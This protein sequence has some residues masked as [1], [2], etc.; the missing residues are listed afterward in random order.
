MAASRA[1]RRQRVR[2]GREPAV[3]GARAP[4]PTAWSSSTSG[5]RSS[6]ATTRP[7]RSSP[8]G[9]ATPWSR[10]PSPPWPPT[11]CGAGAPSASSSCSARP[12]GSSACGPCRWPTSTG[13]SG[14]LVVVEDISERRRLENVRRDFVANISHELKTP[15]RRARPCWPRRCS[16]RTTPTV[17][18]RLAERLATEAFRV[19]Q[20]D[21]RPA[22]A[23][24]GSRSP[25]GWPP[26]TSAWRTFVADAADRVRPA[27]EQRG[28]EIDVERRAG[29][30]VGG[31]RPPPARVGGDQPAR[32]RGE[33]QR[34]GLARSQ[35]RVPHR[36]RAGSTSPSRDHG[37]GIPRRDL[38][39]IFERF[40]RVDRARSRETGGTGPRARHRPPRRHQP[41]GRGPGRVPRGRG[42][43]VHAAA[44]RPG[45]G[46]VAVTKEAG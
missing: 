39:R 22:R 32:Q 36:R 6:T 15:G 38:E 27:A 25:P 45:P 11:R 43:D 19:G 37:I 23:V 2:R 44:A 41:P 13:R 31:R 12:A 40:Y 29:P 9:T 4:S 28:I 17:T 24:A 21:R 35:V 20:H 10:R 7:P 18:R 30:A 16:T 3:V 33:V 1:Q 34:A 46:P 8:P 14:V 26:T 42:L 5:A